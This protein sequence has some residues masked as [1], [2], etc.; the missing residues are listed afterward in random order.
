[1]TGS[2]CV[3]DISK[4]A[5]RGI[6]LLSLVLVPSISMAESWLD[7]DP[8]A[9]WSRAPGFYKEGD[10]WFAIIHAASN[11]IGVKLKGDFTDG[12][13]H[14]ISLTPT[15][16]GKF[17]W[18]KGS[19]DAF[20]RPPQHGDKY[21]F[22]FNDG[23]HSRE[24][25]DPAA[26]WVEH[27]GLN[28]WS[29]VFLSTQF[30]W[31]DQQWDR[32]GWE[33]Y[34]IY[35]VHPL[36][37]TDRNDSLAPLDQVTEEMD[38][39]G[40]RDYIN[41]LK[42]TAVQLLPVNEFPTD[43]SWGYNPSFFY[44]VEES[45]GGPDALKRLV[46]TAHQNGMAVILDVVLNHAGSS[47]NILDSIDR[48]TYLD[49][50]T[51]W[52]PLINFDNDI[53]RHFFIQNL[54]YLAQEFH[55]DGFRFD[56]TRTM[57]TRTWFV[58]TPGSGGGWDLLRQLRPAI[59]SVDPR[60]VLIAE[61]LPDW[62]GITSEDVGSDVGGDRHGPMDGQ[63]A[64]TF[65]DNFKMV[66]EG[67]HLDHL[68]GVFNY[69]GDS[70]HD[71]VIYTESHDEVGNEDKRI[72]K[73]AR[74]G[75]GW[76]MDQIALTGTVLGRGIPM[77]FMGQEGGEDKQFHI[78]WWND[79][80]PLDSYENDQGRKKIRAWYR[81]MNEV[82]R[83]DMWAFASGTID[84]SHIHDDNGVIAM[85]RDQGDYLIVLN[86]RGHTWNDY[87][88]GVSGRYREIANTSWPAFNIGGVPETTRGSD[89]QHIH[90]VRIPAYG[91]V[92]LQRAP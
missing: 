82:R 41:G 10:D 37:F 50:D 75:K 53:A 1:M 23:I 60:I 8:K 55:I 91:A 72:A 2:M 59:K 32:P 89:V 85:T 46:N 80:L 17:W 56:H 88:V 25:Q 39:D 9:I 43:T 79:R 13:S 7:G 29:K 58:T 31:N 42:V 33:Y 26:R 64:D 47:D 62:W 92:V 49:G 69:F 22:V 73:I 3:A 68:Y 19:D 77:A 27:S 24:V 66:L 61:E 78:D 57:H 30:Q 87:N 84:I 65:H 21:R 74:D 40:A 45:Y 16:D 12:D 71:G 36:R 5:R 90:S 20:V 48:D 15:P 11:V 4:Q 44:A 51:K 52:G 63:W 34:N 67:K 18:F 86:F 35:Q 81:K 14:S 83:A 76:E 6:L 38:N 70:W 28:G 54:I